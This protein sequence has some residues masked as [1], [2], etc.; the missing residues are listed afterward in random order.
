MKRSLGILCVIPFGIAWVVNSIGRADELSA[1][2]ATRKDERG[3]WIHEVSSPF[4]SKPTQVRVLPPDNMDRKISHSVIFVLPVEAENQSKYG[5][6]LEEIRRLDLHNSHRTIFV[7]PTFSQLPWYADHPT[8]STVRQESHLIAGILPFVE[9]NYPTQR[10]ARGR[11][12]LG[13]SKSGWGA[14]SLLLRHPDKF[15]RA[16]AWDAPLMMDKPGKYGSGDI[17]GSSDNFDGY[18]LSK[19]VTARAGQFQDP[20]DKRLILTGYGNFR[21]EH[22]GM[23]DLM[24][25]LGVAHEYRDGPQRPHT[26]HSGWVKEA[27]ELLDPPQPK[28]QN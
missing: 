7:A 15:G 9:K 22:V 3:F 27:V 17:F 13:F 11:L 6:G 20:V 19:L 5:D 25:K 10:D 18:C 26:W 16:V 1:V 23:H 4:Q 2:S 28:S 14:W 21:N 12:L 24:D 8:Q